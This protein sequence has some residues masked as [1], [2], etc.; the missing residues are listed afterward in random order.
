VSQEKIQLPERSIDAKHWTLP[1]GN[2]DGSIQMDFWTEG[3]RLLRIDIPSQMLTVIRDDISAVSARVLTLARPNDEPIS[4]Q[5]NGFGVAG[6]LSKPANAQGRLPAV[7]LMSGSTT[8][9]DEFVAGI[10]IFAQLATSLAEAGF[11]AVRYDKRGTGQSGG[12]PES[13]TYDDYAADAREVVVYLSKRKDVDPKRIAV[14]GFGEG[15]WIAIDLA[16]KEHAVF[17]RSCCSARR[18][19]RAPSWSLNSSVTCSKGARRPLRHN[20]KPLNSRIRSC[21]R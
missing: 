18:R 6:T 9:R 2:A 11:I 17:R 15:G 10:P 1:F 12:R 19:P 3:S 20:R 21:R 14:L 8:D 16:A 7:V 13:A 4:V 5:A